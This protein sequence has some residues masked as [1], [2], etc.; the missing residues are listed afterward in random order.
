MPGI[1]LLRTPAH[2]PTGTCGSSA[3]SNLGW[4]KRLRSLPSRQAGDLNQG[5]R[6]RAF[7]RSIAAAPQHSSTWASLVAWASLGARC[8]LTLRCWHTQSPLG[9][10]PATAD[11]LHWKFVQEQRSAIGITDCLDY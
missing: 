9:Q 11:G 3:G 1:G 5:L 7:R 10:L 6:R 2:P 8:R 4:P